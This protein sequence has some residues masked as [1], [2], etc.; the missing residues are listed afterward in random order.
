[1][2]LG[3]GSGV[4]ADAAGGLT[5]FKR[6]W[7]TGTRQAFFCGRVFDRTTYDALT[8]ALPRSTSGY[9]P[10]YRCGEFT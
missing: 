4:T 1:L 8:A 3:A 2:N 5:A 7:A 10:A 9:F 6:G